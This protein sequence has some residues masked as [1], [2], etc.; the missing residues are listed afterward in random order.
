MKKVTKKP[1]KKSEV[2]E[3][4]HI[5]Y[6]TVDTAPAMRKFKTLDDMRIFFKEFEALYPKKNQYESGSFL[7]FCITNISGKIKFL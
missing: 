1:T 2:N 5:V 3:P 7:D 4:Y 6:Y